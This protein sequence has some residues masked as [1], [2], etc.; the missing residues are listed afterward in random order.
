MLIK[1]LAVKNFRNYEEEFFEFSDGINIL[2]GKNAP[3]QNQ[4][5]RG[6]VLY[7]HGNLS[8]NK[9][10]QAAY[11]K[12]LFVRGDFGRGKVALRKSYALG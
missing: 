2:F 3:G 5:R 6:G 7:M 10:G 4:L 9:A 1:N 12:R 11:K 8:E